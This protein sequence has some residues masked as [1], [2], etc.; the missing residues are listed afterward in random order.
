ML[1]PNTIF[2]RPLS[3]FILVR[4]P[5][6]SWKLRPRSPCTSTCLS[7]NQFSRLCPPFNRLENSQKAI[8][9]SIFRIRQSRVALVSISKSSSSLFKNIMPPQAISII[10]MC[11]ASHLLSSSSSSLHRPSD[12][13]RS[14]LL[15]ED[16]DPRSSE[17]EGELHSLA[18]RI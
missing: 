12:P 8:N 17:A 3:A 4:L 13:R 7:P 2:L 16:N 14:T 15:R 10:G 1:F 11:P 18:P 6:K 5:S 9:V